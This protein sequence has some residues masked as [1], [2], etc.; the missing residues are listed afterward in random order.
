[1]RDKSQKLL[2]HGIDT[3]QC[4]YYLKPGASP[5]ICFQKL[6]IQKERIRATKNK[7]QLPLDM[8]NSKFLLH[9]SGSASGYPFIL[10]N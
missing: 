9:H 8:G 6:A 5:G 3:L 7:N 10:K 1:M 2:L 4:A